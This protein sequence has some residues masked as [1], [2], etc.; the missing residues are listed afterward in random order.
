MERSPWHAGEQQLQAHVGVAERMEAF[1]RKVIRNWMPDQ[2]REFYRQLPFML[3]GAV[4]AQGR[5]WASVL[6]GEPGFADSPDPEH[7]HFTSHPAA[8]DPAQLRNGEPIGLLGIELHTRRRNRLNG[9]VAN[10][11]ADG[12]ELSVD[13]AFGNCP[14]YIQLRQFQRVPLSDPQTRP[15][16]HLNSLDEAASALITSAD[17]FFVASYVDV[18]GQRSVDVSHRGGQPGFVRIEGNRLTI[19]DFA[20]NL[21][22]NTLGNL[23]LNPKAGLLFIDFS[24]GDLLHLS[25]RTEI[26]LEDPQIEAFQGAERLWTFEVEQVVRRPAALA[27]RWRF[28]GMS[29]TSLLTGNWAEADARLQA[30]ALG[31]QWRPLRVAKI[32]AESRHIRSIYLEPVDGAGLPVFLAG[33][34]LP[35]RFTLDGEVHI[36][37]YSLSSA[38]SDGFYR[39]SV[40]REGLI[41]SHLHQQIQVGDVLEARA[42]QGHF[43]VAPLA[44]RPLVLLAAG[45]GITPLLSMLREVVYQGLRTRGI[46]PTLLLQSSRSLADQ[47]FRQELDRLLERSGEAVRVLRL[48][49]QPEADAHEGEDF[50]LTGRID[51]AVLRNL[52]DVD[53]FD[54]IDFVLCG[55]GGFT[56]GLYDSLRELDVR[57]AQIHAETF[58]PSTLKRQADADAIVIEQPPAATTS[59]A[60]VFERSAKEARWQPEGGSLLELAESRGLRPEFSCRGGSCGTCKTRLVSGA[61]NYPQPP[62]EIPEA[63]HVLIC[64]AVPA[65][66]AQP[67]VLDL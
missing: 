15:A 55:P 56:Q 3:L 34:H 59:V 35:L 49:S 41:S 62:A 21:H 5:P 6:E 37:T 9:H 19:P 2:H 65:Q 36:R 63:G 8:D 47:P 32:E 16:Q 26:L 12:F 40:K 20:G 58:G 50:D 44:R 27:L 24:T 29:P 42:P 60:V 14:Q 66:S 22:F 13:Q 52:L 53:D 28:D 18:D 30:Q 38:P 48:L 17:T 7:L 4:D 46:R 31:N 11:T 23:L 51:G 57:D 39:I 67:L 33:Q 25:G 64:C 1:G 45:V 54:Q 10:L 61:V 43:T